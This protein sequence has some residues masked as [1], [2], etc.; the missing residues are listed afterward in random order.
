MTLWRRALTFRGAEFIHTA[1]DRFTSI[2]DP[3]SSGCERGSMSKY[4]SSLYDFAKMPMCQ[5]YGCS[6]KPGK[7]KKKSF[8]LCWLSLRLS[9]SDM[10]SSNIYAEINTSPVISDHWCSL[11][12]CEWFS[13]Y[14][15]CSPINWQNLVPWAWNLRFHFQLRYKVSQIMNKKK[16]AYW[17]LKGDKWKF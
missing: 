16:L 7:G 2:L 6:N 8:I 10:T 11:N 12:L 15:G 4:A 14:C 9:P 17:N 13:T 5:A 3:S 1:H